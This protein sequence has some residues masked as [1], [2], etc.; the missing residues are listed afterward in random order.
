MAKLLFLMKKSGKLWRLHTA[1]VAGSN[2]ASPTT[3][4]REHGLGP[5]PFFLALSA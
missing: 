3:F 2:P 1:G 5:V 4:K